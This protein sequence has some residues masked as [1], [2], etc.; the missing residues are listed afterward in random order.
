MAQTILL[1]GSSGGFKTSN[2]GEFSDFVCTRYAGPEYGAVTRAI[3]GDNFGPLRPRI[4]SGQVQMWNLRT[5]PDPLSCLIL[6]GQGY[7]PNCLEDGRAIF[8]DRQGYG[9]Q[10]TTPA[11]YAGIG[12]YIVEGLH[13]N[14][15]LIMR[16]LEKKQRAT[17]EPLVA[18][19][20]E[21]VAKLKVQYAMASRGTY[22]FTQNQ[23]HGYFALG[24]AGLPV[25]WVLATSHE[26]RSIDKT[27]KKVVGI[28]LAGKAMT[29]VI[30]Q[31]F[32][33]VLHFDRFAQTVMLPADQAKIAGTAKVTRMGTRAHFAPHMDSE[34]P[35]LMW[36]AKLG[37][38][39][40]KAQEIYRRFP[41]GYMNLQLAPG[42]EYITS[43]RT[44]LE[45][46]DPASSSAGEVA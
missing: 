45:M 24:F 28:G 21:T 18:I 12:G 37:V 36:P 43:V 17:G 42:G 32:D 39:P 23:T 16:S 15:M 10:L 44:L 20:E 2:A 25:P 6:A 11:E 33:H 31:W 40:E 5:T 1:Y 35:T 7:W 34:V 27:G 4:A 3:C 8:D 19:H 26:A 30:T 46:I 14:A 38:T 41:A 22:G 29:E 9:L 13:E